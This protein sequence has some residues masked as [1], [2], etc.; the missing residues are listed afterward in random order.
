[1]KSQRRHELQKNV[2]NVELAKIMEFLKAKGNYLSWGLLI[3]AVIVLAGVL[4]HRH[5]S[6]QGAE[7]QL[8]YD[9]LVMGQGLEAELKP[10]ERLD[11]LQRLAA[12]DSDPVRAAMENYNVG[13]E[14]AQKM[15]VGANDAERKSFA[16][17]A[18]AYYRSIIE[19]Y[20]KQRLMVAKAH[21]GMA[22]VDE[23]I[24]DFDGA[25]REY[26]AMIG[27]MDLANYPLMQFA[28]DAKTA[29]DQL[30][31][32]VVMAS[33]APSTQP[34]TSSAPASRPAGGAESMPASVPASAPGK[35]KD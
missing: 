1:M 31:T 6:S 34:A 5:S 3:V 15:L 29:M 4:W 25:G 16:D 24:K 11:R 10:D 30:K 14:Y 9:R 26:D 2:L 8:E 21:L 13:N 7:Y 32:P 20:P 12:N 35:A 23:S 22:K 17:Q 33:T 19:K 18:I 27:M 28:R